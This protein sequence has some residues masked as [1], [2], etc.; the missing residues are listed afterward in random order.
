MNKFLNSL[1]SGIVVVLDEAYDVFI[2]VLDFPKSLGYLKRNN[3]II[4]KTFSKAYGL[5]GLRI[6]YALA[7]PRLIDSMQKAR[8]PFNVNILAQV[9]AVAALQDNQ[10]LKKSR[11]AVLI[12]KRYLY[13][14]LT[15]LGLTYI[16]S[17]TNFILINT[18]SNGYNIY[19]RMLRFGVIVRDMQQY[20][21]RN[22][23]RVTVGTDYENKRFI[24][25]LKRI[26]KKRG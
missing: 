11:K 6:G 23:I 20:G 16:P 12:G 19:K 4:L 24:E 5:A 15:K 18:K 10:F 7:N 26:L 17:V 25:V 3:V 2:D 9:G 22:F 13:G 14:Q 8:P 21:L 1:P